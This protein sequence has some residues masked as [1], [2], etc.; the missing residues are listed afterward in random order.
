MGLKPWITSSAPD[1]M[2]VG[3]HPNLLGANSYVRKHVDF[4]QFARAV[5][6]LGLYWLLL[7]EVP[8]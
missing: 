7:N 1:N 6:Q 2:R 3:I 8:Y 5:Q 4:D